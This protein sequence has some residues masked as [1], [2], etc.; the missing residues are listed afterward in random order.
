LISETC[1]DP[2]AALRSWLRARAKNHP[3]RCYGNALADAV[4]EGRAV[5]VKKIQRLWREEGLRE[6]VRRRRKRVDATTVEPIP[7]DAPD[8]VWAV[9]FPFD[10][11]ED[12]RSVKSASIIDEHTRECVGG[13]VERSI[14]ADR[15]VDE[16]ERIIAHR[17][18]Q[19]VSRCDNG[20]EFVSQALAD[21]AN[22]MVGISYMPPGQPWR[23]GY[24]K[25]FNSRVRDECLN[26]NSFYSLAHA[27]GFD[28]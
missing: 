8:T 23:N 16:L 21:W 27:Q 24:V 4:S 9:D 15:L 28:R 25:S 3:R 18:L 10:A 22:D 5:N 26:L 7:A 14:T 13:L 12:G 19:T 11:T 1:A 20:P 2:D 17:G 6:I